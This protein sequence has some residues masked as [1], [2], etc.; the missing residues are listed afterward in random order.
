MREEVPHYNLP[1]SKN[2]ITRFNMFAMP[3]FN[4][5]WLIYDSYLDNI[6]SDIPYQTH[7]KLLNITPPFLILCKN[8]GLFVNL[9]ILN[10]ALKTNCRAS[11]IF[12]SACLI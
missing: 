11:V 9:S 4:G 1:T 10:C 12:I 3:N 7:N 2:M 5:V 8:N 6:P